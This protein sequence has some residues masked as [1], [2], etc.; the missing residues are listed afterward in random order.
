VL[1]VTRSSCPTTLAVR[2]GTIR[3]WCVAHA[4]VY[5]NAETLPKGA[6]EETARSEFQRG[7]RTAL[8]FK[9]VVPRVPAGAAGGWGEEG[10]GGRVD[11]VILKDVCGRV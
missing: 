10:G 5:A 7:G 2:F 9:S 3:H 11:Q 6:D 8:F 4:T 1:D